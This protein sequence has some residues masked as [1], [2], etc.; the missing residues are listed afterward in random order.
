MRLEEGLGEDGDGYQGHQGESAG[1][2]GAKCAPMVH[3]SPTALAGLGR[4]SILSSTL[5]AG[6]HLAASVLADDLGEG[7]VCIAAE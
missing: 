4:I 1:E 2:V 5:G 7:A 3:A 6:A